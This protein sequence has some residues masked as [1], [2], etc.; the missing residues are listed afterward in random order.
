M[1]TL[2]FLAKRLVW[3]GTVNYVPCVSLNRV[4]GIP[5]ELCVGLVGVAATLY[6]V[7][8]GMK[9]VVWTDVVQ[10]FVLFGGLIAMLIVLVMSTE[11]GLSG[12][13][14]VGQASGRTTMVKLRGDIL[15][16]TTLWGLIFA[17]VIGNIAHYRTDQMA[18]QRCLSARITSF[19]TGP[20]AGVFL[21]AVLT[22]RSRDLPCLLGALV[23]WVVAAYVA[24]G[25]E[26]IFWWWSFVGCFVTV[27]IGLGLSTLPK[28]LGWL[29]EDD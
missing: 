9:A 20:M 28:F 23:G 11:G 13:W 27:V 7:L 10:F 5:L 19:F 17:S 15:H 25:T 12:I 26:I 2:A 1:G 8:G 22:R 6:T 16:D 24:I 4:S 21:M 18:F 3:L 14:S 29:N